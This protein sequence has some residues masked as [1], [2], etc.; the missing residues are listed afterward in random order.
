MAFNDLLKLDLPDAFPAHEY[1]DFMAAARAVLLPN[2]TEAWK[3]FAGASNLI[4]WRFRSSFEDM[5]TYIASWQKYG[6]NVSFEEIYLRER[7]LFGMFSSGVSCVESVCYASYA[8]ASHP[9]V[10]GLV[11]GEPEQRRCNPSQLRNALGSHSRAKALVSDLTALTNS[12]EWN[13]WVD[14]RN[15]MTHRSNLPRII[16]A[17]VGSTPPPA[18]ALQFAA[19]SSTPAFEADESHLEAL[20]L[21]LS[22]SLG[23]LLTGG[24]H[25][26]S[27]P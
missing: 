6:A 25:L 5:R 17:A 27:G 10:L 11:F 7:A 12:N 8:L 3:E 4:G 20:F 18:K 19:T 14:L 26:A 22:K 2:K 1:S 15:R 13:L 23:Q 24:R 9:S 21:W 16:Y